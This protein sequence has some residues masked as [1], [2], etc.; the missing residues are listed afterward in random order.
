MRQ[1]S[2]ENI[3]RRLPVGAEPLTTGGVHFRVWC[4][5]STKIKVTIETG[6]GEEFSIELE[7]EGN[8]YF[9]GFSSACK[10]G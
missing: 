10:A 1:L 8:G 2:A 9:S 7:N 3:S 4:P 5:R 6:A